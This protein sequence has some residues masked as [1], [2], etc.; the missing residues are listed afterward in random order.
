[1]WG[2]GKYELMEGRGEGKRR[3][4]ILFPASVFNCEALQA[5]QC[6]RNTLKFD[7]NYI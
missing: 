3:V 5:A 6:M 1:M 2:H 7:L 4:F